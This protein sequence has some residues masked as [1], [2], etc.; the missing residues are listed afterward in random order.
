VTEAWQS[1]E[2]DVSTIKTTIAKTF[3]NVVQDSSFSLDYISINVTDSAAVVSLLESSRVA[4]ASNPSDP[5]LMSG[6]EHTITLNKVDSKWVIQQ[7]QYEDDIT[8]LVETSTM[9]EILKNIQTNHEMMTNQSVSNS[10]P[11]VKLISYPLRRALLTLYSYSNSSATSYSDSYAQSTGPVPAAVRNSSGWS[12]SYPANYQF[13]SSNDC[14]NF[15][16]QAIFAG[17]AS[18]DSDANY[19]YPDSSH[20]SDW[21]YYKFST[22][23]GG[24]QPWV[25]VGYLYSF[26]TSNTNRGAVGSSVGSCDSSLN[27]GDPI[28]MKSGSNWQHAVIIASGSGCTNVTVNSHTVNYYHQQESYYSGY[29]WYPVNI[30]GYYK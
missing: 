15:V 5:V 22:T 17:T 23:A 26:L 12:S 2:A 13:Y 21:W 7:D 3:G 16:S 20:Y 29:S 14:T 25:S 18:T 24:S 9:E 8:R 4:Y 30:T 11:P 27:N 10:A 28:F 1:K 6:L 19:F